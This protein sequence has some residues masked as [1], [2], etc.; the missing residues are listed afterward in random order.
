MPTIKELREITQTIKVKNRERPWLYVSLQRGP[1]IYLTKLLLLTKITANQ[2]SI[3]TIVSGLFGAIFIYISGFFYTL[4]GI[5]FFIFSVILDKT[6]GE[7]A[8]FKKVF[9]LR[10]VFLDE[11]Y[12]LVIPSLF[13]VSMT[14]SLI[15]QK[16]FT[17]PYF[18]LLGSLAAISMSFIR[19]GHSLAPGIFVKKYLKHKELFKLP[20][21]GEKTP[22]EK[23]KQES[24]ILK[25]ILNV[26]HQFQEFFMILLTYLIVLLIEQ[27]TDLEN[28]LVLLT[29][30]YGIL[31]PLVFIENTIK[32][33]LQVEQRVSNLNN[34]FKTGE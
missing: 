27:Y 12:H 6:D 30:I 16:M 20:P 15:D 31:L 34:R 17:M 19:I 25:I 26:V 7:I 28:I 10:G 32:G 5:I 14:I 23:I 21:S 29:A 8:R 11:T 18:L 24:N 22:V 13:F 9:S 4:I 3:L 1:S 33:F 2:V